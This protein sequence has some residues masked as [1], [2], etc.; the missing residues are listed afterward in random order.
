[1]DELADILHTDAIRMR[2]F[3]GST[4]K[5]IVVFCGVGTQRSQP[6]PIEMFASATQGAQHHALF[7]TDASRCWLNTPGFDVQIASAVQRVAARILPSKVTLIGNSMGGTM[8]LLLSNMIPCDS[9]LAFAPQFSVHPEIVPEELRWS[10][11]RNKIE[12]FS[13]PQIDELD[14]QSRT[15]QIVHGDSPDELVHALRFPQ[16]QRL[17][18]YIV[19]GTD[20]HLIKKLKTDGALTTLVKHAINQRPGRFRGA[21]QKHGA[22][23]RSEYEAQHPFALDNVALRLTG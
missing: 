2:Y 3:K 17:R 15:I 7:V 1:M 23:F 4:D 9:V 10:Y 5:L 13:Y 8:A 22:M 11:F 19:P 12:R 14:P 6:P 18:H 20:H 16:L 21:M